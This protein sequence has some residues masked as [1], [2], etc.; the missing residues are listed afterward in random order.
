ALTDAD[1]ANILSNSNMENMNMI[2]PLNRSQKI[3]N[4]IASLLAAASTL[5]AAEAGAMWDEEILRKTNIS[6][7]KQKIELDKQLLNHM[8]ID[9]FCIDT[10]NDVLKRR[11][12]AIDECIEELRVFS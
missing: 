12:C 9:S 2:N 8:K 7:K 4:A 5:V 1:V 3:R 10:A 11:E 6:S